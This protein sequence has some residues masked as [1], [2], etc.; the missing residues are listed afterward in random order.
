MARTRVAD[1]VGCDIG[2]GPALGRILVIESEDLGDL[3]H[4]VEL[5]LELHLR[6]VTISSH[7]VALRARCL[8]IAARNDRHGEGD[9][10]SNDEADDPDEGAGGAAATRG[11]AEVYLVHELWIRPGCIRARRSWPSL[12]SGPG[13]GVV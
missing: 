1:T 13:L 6:R 9:Q 10:E 2:G 8:G 7:A 12:R 3:G 4:G 11:I 5:D